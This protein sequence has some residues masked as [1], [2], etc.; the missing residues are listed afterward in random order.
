MLGASLLKAYTQEPRLI[1]EGGLNHKQGI[2]QCLKQDSPNQIRMALFAGKVNVA[3]TLILT[4]YRNL[5]TILVT[6]S[7]IL[8]TAGLVLTW[9]IV[10]SWNISDLD[11]GLCGHIGGFAGTTLSAFESCASLLSGHKFKSLTT[12]HVRRQTCGL[13]SGSDETISE[14]SGRKL[15]FFAPQK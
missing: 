3:S 6:L 12:E 5:L 4:L 14:Y 13:R 9:W 10:L 8:L 7:P 2:R 15:A 1:G 11:G